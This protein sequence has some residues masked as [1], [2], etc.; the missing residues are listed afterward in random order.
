MLVQTLGCAQIVPRVAQ[1]DA[2]REKREKTK[3]LGF[4]Q[5]SASLARCPR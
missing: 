5:V 3:P 4:G 1:P 2:A